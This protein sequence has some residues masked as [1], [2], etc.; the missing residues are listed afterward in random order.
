MESPMILGPARTLAEVLCLSLIGSAIALAECPVD[1]VVVKGRVDHTPGNARV[2]VQ[3]IYAKDAPGEAAEASAENGTFTVPVEYLTQSK[4]P[5][6]RNLPDKCDR[7]P[8]I[9]SVTLFDASEEFDPVSLVFPKDFKMTDPSAYTLR[10]E[11]VLN[12]SR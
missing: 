9:V 4:H 8:I 2:R 7:K 11:L 12:G 5:L 3:L 10:S 1:T 6:L